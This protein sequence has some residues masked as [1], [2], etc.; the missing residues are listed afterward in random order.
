M[1][2]D[3]AHGAMMGRRMVFGRIIG[4]IVLA[5][6]PVDVELSL[7]GSVADPV[8]S[9]VHGFGTFLF[10][11]AGA[12]AHCGGVVGEQGSGRLGVAEF[13]E[14]DAKGTGFFSIVEEGS[15]FGFSSGGKDFAHD[16]AVDEDGAV[17]GG[18][19][20]G[21]RGIVEWTTAQVVVAGSTGTCFGLG[22]VGGIAFDP[23][24]H[25][26]AFESD[27][28]IGMSGTIVEEAFEGFQGG[29][30]GSGL[31]LANGAKCHQHGVVH[32]TC[33]KQECANDFLNMAR[34]LRSRT[35]PSGSGVAIW[36]ALEYV[37]LDQ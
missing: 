27:N 32:G 22:Q 33:I 19:W 13:L 15:K 16:V 14:R 10:D 7:A 12:N 20:V 30:G 4:E 11:G 25:V 17:W 34:V 31:L 6:A 21:R 18:R 24:H 26:A 35:A 37:G 5:R 29:S 23:Q 36:G 8:E 1:E 3:R 28:G 9:H 2:E